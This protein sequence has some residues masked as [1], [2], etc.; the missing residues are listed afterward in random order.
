MGKERKRGKRLAAYNKGDKNVVRVKIGVSEKTGKPRY[1][2]V[3]KSKRDQAK[4]NPA[5]AKWVKSMKQARKNLGITKDDGFV[6]L[7]RG[8][9]GKKLYKETKELYD[10]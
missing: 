8:A 5:L 6:V 10:A 2:Y 3:S 4:K 1:R 9:L 7:N